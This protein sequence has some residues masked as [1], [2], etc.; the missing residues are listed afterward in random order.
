MHVLHAAQQLR[1]AYTLLRSNNVSSSHKLCCTILT[2]ELFKSPS[3]GVCI[4]CKQR[5]SMSATLRFRIWQMLCEWH[6]YLEAGFVCPC[7]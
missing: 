2:E 4:I 5:V 3:A 6:C 7:H 1:C